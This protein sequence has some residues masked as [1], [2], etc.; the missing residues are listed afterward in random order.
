[1]SR[2]VAACLLFGLAWVGYSQGII[3]T[4]VGTGWSFPPP[5][6]PAVNAPLGT[7]EGVALD[8]SGNLYI[9]DSDNNM[10]FR[11]AKDG[12]LTV[13]AGNGFAGF[14]GDGG[15]ATNAAMSLILTSDVAVDA[16]GNIYLADSGNQRVREISG[17]IITTVAGDGASGFS[18]D[19]GPAVSA[20]L[21]FPS[22]V[23]V[24][25][26]GNLYIADSGNNRVRKVSGGIITTVA[27]NGVSGFS[28][29]GGPATRGELAAPGAV[30]VDAAGNL[31]IADTGNNRVRKVSIGVIT[32]VAG[33]GIEG[34]SGD[35][36]PATS[37]QMSFPDGV[38]LDAAGNLYVSDDDRVREVLG[39]I[40]TT[41]AGSSV[42]GA[43]S[44][45][46]GAATSA[47]L[48]NPFGL[49]VD[50]EGNLYI[51]DSSNCRVRKVSGGVI[52]TVAGDGGFQ[53]AGDGGP[54]VDASLNS[55]QDVAVSAAGDLYIADFL[56]SRVRKVS[57]GTVTT[58]AGNG[59][60]ASYG[61]GGPATSASLIPVGIAVDASGSLYISDA[62][63][64][65]V[66][67]ISAGVITTV[68]GGGMYQNSSIGDGGPATSATLNLPTDLTL[69]AAGNLYIAD[70]LNYRVR[71]VSNGIITT[72]AGGGTSRADGVA[73]TSALIGPS[74]ITVDG[75]GN[76]YIAEYDLNVVR[77]VSGGIIRTIAGN[78]SAGFSGDGGL[79][80]QA[81]LNGPL[82]LTLDAQ[83]NLYIADSNNNVVRSVSGGIINTVAGNG[84]AG[85]S[86]DGG[87]ATNA[88]ILTAGDGLLNGLASDP[89]GDLYIVDAGNNRIREVLAKPPAL[90]IST[91]LL[92]LSGSSGG[93]QVTASFDVITDGGGIGVPGV[94]FAS[95]VSSASW[96][97]AMPVSGSTP[98]LIT[99]TADPAELTAGSYSGAVTISVP[100]ANPAVATVNVQ[101]AVGAAI[102]ASLAVDHNHLS[103]TYAS[104]SAARTQT[105]TVSNT[106]SGAPPFTAAVTPNPGQSASWLSVTP[107]SGTATPSAPVAMAVTA[108]PAGLNP[109]TYTA[110]VVVSSAAGSVTVTVTM[111]ITANPLVMLLSQTGLTYT[112][113]QNG[114]A[115]AP[116][117]FSVLNL[118]SG[119]LNWSVQTS[120]LGGVNNWLSV[121]PNIGVSTPGSSI[122]APSVSVSVNPAGLAPGVYYGLVAVTAV[123]AANTPQGVVA[124]LQVLPAGTDIAPVVE[125]NSLVFTGVVGSSSPSSQNVMVY[126]PTGTNKSFRSGIVTVNGGSWLETLPGDATIPSNELVSIVV[127][128]VVNNL[129]AGTY[130]GT[131]TLQ[132]SDGR[133]NQVPV[134]FVVTGAGGGP[135][136]AGIAKLREAE[137]PCVAAQLTPSLVT[138]GVG[139]SVPAGYPQ[140]LEAQVV[141]NCG[142]PQVD[143]TVYVSF[144]NGDAPVKLQSLGNG[145]WDG[146]W[147]VGATAQAAVTLTVASQN[148]AG[149]T[150]QSTLNG[151]LSATMPAPEIFD[152]G[153]VNAA[154]LVGAPVAPGEL[155]S[156]FGQQLAGGESVAGN[157]TL[158]TVLAGTTV[159]IGT[160][161][162]AG[163]QYQP[164]PLLFTN[165]GA[166]AQVNAQVPL[167]VS[168]NTNQQIL[169]QWG[170]AY[171]PPVYVDV[172]ATAPAV[173][174][175]GQG[176]AIITDAN[177]L[178]GPTNPLHAGDVA[179]IWCTG[180]GAATPA[181]TDGALTP[182][183]PYYTTPNPVVTI[184]GQSAGVLFS[185]L[186]PGYAGLYQINVTVPSGIAPGDSV[187]VTVTAGGQ[188]SAPVVTSVR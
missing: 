5:P 140:G 111:T 147:P 19:G 102:Q 150:G 104:T 118:G 33:T 7:T 172:G 154:S 89:S 63:D 155:I 141:D 96:L 135:G 17:G 55:P 158:P 26:A 156:V 46:G 27:G 75:A 40:I 124:V 14:S 37:A 53:F 6:L 186:T 67:L 97:S 151:G 175:Y 109:G 114:G 78:G 45:D 38:T 106:G 110:N 8:Q 71:K 187:R 177:G 69:D 122:A 35:G 180:L 148:G 183:T 105:I 113:V 68:V 138:L 129:A 132:F 28:G 94:G 103:F 54:P 4:A 32:T 44:G 13:M 152:G 86:G 133:V 66:R 179:V 99:M 90:E 77:E 163:G 47:N 24:D 1:M 65:C 127:Q 80:T 81:S 128:P 2:S 82:G 168:A 123:G 12:T 117:T 169:L 181:A 143:G 84:V 43:F 162:V 107:T 62:G 57:N 92:A 174:A 51:A 144:T 39:G 61:D 184:G 145:L 115:V 126:D 22:G 146:T 137:T 176:E 164:M 173:F 79:A 167:E 112:G 21:A 50:A 91:T 153:V 134:Q 64:S 139:F 136:A 159:S 165:G 119:T 23:A 25:A 16:A 171:A 31:Y 41:V 9:A 85:F 30:A 100:N 95:Q 76:L 157:G 149:I 36:G 11:M 49:A 166:Q 88:S 56:N 74:A 160:Q 58:V 120:V 83:G 185:G 98:G 131:L 87:L 10:V 20:Q 72:V 18:G 29:D 125:P 130:Q 101:F 60:F 73:A 48:Y 178:V 142:N 188:T 59:V 170:T 42:L 3:T 182:D 34:F 52:S 121:T 108:N 15:P 161:G 93:K 116:Q 70:S